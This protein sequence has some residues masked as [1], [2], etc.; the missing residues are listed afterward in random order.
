MLGNTF[1]HLPGIGPSSE[2]SLWQAGLHTWEDFLAAKSTPLGP[3]RTGLVRQG[4]EES[5]AARERRDADWFA[6]R[7]RGAD[8]WRL[9]P[10]FLSGAGYLDIETDGQ[11]WPTITS[12]AL[13]HGGVVRVYVHGENLEDF[14]QDVRAVEVL[15]S[16][17]GKCFDAPILERFLGAKLPKA[18]VDMRHVLAKLGRTGGLKA[19][20][21]AYGLDR[22]GLSGLD[23][24]SAV[25]LWRLWQETR[26]RRVLDTM[27]AYNVAD[28]LSLEV[29]LAMA[30][31]ELLLDTPFAARHTLPIPALG[32]NP[33]EPDPEVVAR[34]AGFQVI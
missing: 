6:A 7:L 24:W 23:G 26:D 34:V 29:L 13:Y 16:F 5:L 15:V 31:D 18:H 17:N 32:E 9:M 25:L 12:I 4:L 8:T 19:C 30:V 28:V 33:F 10:H 1:R 20:E 3:A 27:L 14:I 2:V 22:C 11:R 21:K